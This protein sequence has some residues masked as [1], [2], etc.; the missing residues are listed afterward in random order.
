MSKGAYIFPSFIKI[1]LSDMTITS[2]K[3]PFT[4]SGTVTSCSMQGNVFFLVLDSCTYTISKNLTVFAVEDSFMEP[5]ENVI[6]KFGLAST[7]LVPMDITPYAYL[8]NFAL[9]EVCVHCTTC[10]FSRLIVVANAGVSWITSTASITSRLS[11]ITLVSGETGKIKYVTSILLGAN[12]DYS[13]IES[14]VQICLN[15]KPI[16]ISKESLLLPNSPIVLTEGDTLTVKCF[17]GIPR[18]TITI[19][20]Y[21]ETV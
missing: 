16:L 10:I 19:F 8:G 17:M 5:V 21:E 13:F 20:G 15:G 7:I 14:K 18:G 1:K 9:Y 6:A 4:S 12:M 11:D 2:Y 3:T